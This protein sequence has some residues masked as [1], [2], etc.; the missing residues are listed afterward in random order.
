M[1]LTFL[2]DNNSLIGTQFLAEPALSML[3]RMAANI[4]STPDIPTPYD[5]RTAQGS[6][7]SIWT[8]LP[9]LTVT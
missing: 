7:C 1:E 5:Q 4:L 9:C 8:G 2:V 6:T 3:F